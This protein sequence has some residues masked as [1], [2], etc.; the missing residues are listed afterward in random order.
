MGGEGNGVRQGRGKIMGDASGKEPSPQR[1]KRFGNG[2]EQN[3]QRCVRMAHG[4]F[5]HFEFE[6]TGEEGFSNKE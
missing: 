5:I 1:T 4:S 3:L 2:N 6:G